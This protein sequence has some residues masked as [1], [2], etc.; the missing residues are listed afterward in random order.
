MI[1]YPIVVDF[2]IIAMR[3]IFFYKSTCYF[4]NYTGQT[5][6]PE[7][8]NLCLSMVWY[9]ISVC[10][11]TYIQSLFIS[12]PYSLGVYRSTGGAVT[13]GLS[14]NRTKLNRQWKTGVISSKRK[15]DKIVQIR[16]DIS[17]TFIEDIP[18]KTMVL[19]EQHVDKLRD[20]DGVVTKG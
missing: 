11:W 8:L 17:I 15:S 7:M 20:C 13:Q 18:E 14:S 6:L 9:S 1:H 2:C 4:I 3:Q 10:L 5:E 16:K 19:S 12:G